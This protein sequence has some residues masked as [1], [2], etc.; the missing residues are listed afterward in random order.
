MHNYQALG[1]KYVKLQKRGKITKTSKVQA[2]Q[3]NLILSSLASGFL[4][5]IQIQ[6]T[7]LG[8]GGEGGRDWSQKDAEGGWGGGGGGKNVKLQTWAT[9]EFMYTT[10]TFWNSLHF[11]AKRSVVYNF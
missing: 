10:Y 6:D 3:T 2:L 7:F 5:R 9:T 4:Q 1:E 11:Q 8:G